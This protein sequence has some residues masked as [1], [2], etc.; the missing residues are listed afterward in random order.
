MSFQV[1]AMKYP[2]AA[3]CGDKSSLLS[4]ASCPETAKIVGATLDGMRDSDIDLAR[5]RL[6]NE[7]LC[8]RCSEL[9]TRRGWTQDQMAT[10]L[11]IPKDRYKKYEIRSPLPG[12]L[13]EPFANVVGEDVAFVLTGRRAKQ[14]PLQPAISTQRRA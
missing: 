10:A 4:S 1:I 2:L 12:Y 5:E 6:F 3:M 8:A 11:G 7:A 13:I 14:A 9:R